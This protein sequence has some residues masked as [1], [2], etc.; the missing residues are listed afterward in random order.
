MPGGVNPRLRLSRNASTSATA[1]YY[2]ARKLTNPPGSLYDYNDAKRG[3]EPPAERRARQQRDNRRPAKPP[4][5]PNKRVALPPKRD[6]DPLCRASKKGRQLLFL[7]H[8]FERLSLL[9][10]RLVKGFRGRGK[11][12]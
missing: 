6:S 7:H 8:A 2:E 9:A 1:A 4:S 11:P 5:H 10:V 12:L 3:L